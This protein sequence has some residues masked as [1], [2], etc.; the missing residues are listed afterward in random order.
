[1]GILKKVFRKNDEY[2][3]PKI[4]V[5]MLIP[6]LEKYKDANILCPFDTKESEFVKT[7]KDFKITYSHINEGNIKD[8]FDYT[9]RELKSF[10]L[11]LSNPPF[12]RKLEILKRL[13]SID[14]PFALLLNLMCLNYQEIGNFFVGK[15]LQL[16]IPDKKISFDG[17]TSSFNSS[18]FCNRFLDKQI[19]FEH[20]ENNNAGRYFNGSNLYKR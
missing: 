17:N 13:Y 6:Y 15:E 9:D 5:Y 3:T 14:V 10:D 8:F 16:L 19:I 4:L 18:Y 12:S 1:M 7:L 20:L 11:I 2:Y